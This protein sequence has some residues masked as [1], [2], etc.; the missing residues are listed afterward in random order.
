MF[1]EEEQRAL[2][3]C[4]LFRKPAFRATA[5]PASLRFI[6]Y[7]SKAC[8]WLLAPRKRGCGPRFTNVLQAQ[9]LWARLA[10]SIFQ[11]RAAVYLA[12]LVCPCK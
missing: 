1:Q 8:S 12:A 9:L 11:G 2:G 3:F 5:P 7:H 6:H 10:P 4:L